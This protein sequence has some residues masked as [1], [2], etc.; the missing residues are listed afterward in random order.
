ME[1]VKDALLKI[2]PDLPEGRHA[3]TKGTF[4][5]YRKTEFHKI[6]AVRSYNAVMRPRMQTDRKSD[7]TLD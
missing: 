6:V 1:Q 3:S 7:I 4:R 5:V 2:L